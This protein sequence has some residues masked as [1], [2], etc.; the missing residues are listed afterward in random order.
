MSDPAEPGLSYLPTD[1]VYEHGF[2]PLKMAF[3]L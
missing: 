3:R 2:D 1:Y